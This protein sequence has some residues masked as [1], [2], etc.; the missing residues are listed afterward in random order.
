MARPR[1]FSPEQI[2]EIRRLY[3][4]GLS[5]IKLGKKFGCDYTTI[6]LNLGTLKRKLKGRP[7]LSYKKPEIYQYQ[8]PK[9][10]PQLDY[11]DIAKKQS[12]IKIVRNTKGKAMR[13]VRG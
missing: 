12:H 3:K 11:E 10:K 4:G 6:L 1:K 7:V 5:S 2:E 8:K 13:V 9:A